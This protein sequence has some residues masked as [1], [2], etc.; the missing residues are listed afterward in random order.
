MISYLERIQYSLIYML[1]KTRY[2]KS[3]R[4]YIYRANQ[5]ISIISSIIVSLLVYVLARME[6]PGAIIG[7]LFLSVAFLLFFLLEKNV[8]KTK[9]FKYRK[10]YPRNKKYLLP[11][12]LM[13]IIGILLL[14]AI[15]FIKKIE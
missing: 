15:Y 1:Y 12:F 14:G 7:M 13:T 6:L 3:G 4:G 2:Y 9:L 11:F 10:T 5:I 8:T